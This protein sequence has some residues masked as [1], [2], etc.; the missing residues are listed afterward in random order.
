[1]FETKRKISFTICFNIHIIKTNE[2]IRLTLH[3]DG[4]MSDL[5][6]FPQEYLVISVRPKKEVTKIL[7]CHDSSHPISER[8]T[9]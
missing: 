7:I 6:Y 4:Y 9:N 1:M 5:S 2:G 8:A 3:K